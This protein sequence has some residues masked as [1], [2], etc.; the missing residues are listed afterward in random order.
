ALAGDFKKYLAFKPDA[1]LILQGHA[2]PRGGADYNKLLSDR[3]V[4]RTK[5]FLVEQGVAADVIET[6]GLGV[7]QPMSADQVKQAVEQ[8]QGLSPAQKA[9]L[10]RNASVL[11][12]PQ[13]P[14]VDVTLSPTPPTPVPH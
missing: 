13:N 11:A 14:P 5:A 2:D 8:E 1:H 9:Q 7:E 6:Q 10:N 4:G 3:R 12:F